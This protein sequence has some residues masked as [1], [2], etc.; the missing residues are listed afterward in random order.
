LAIKLKGEPAAMKNY[1]RVVIIG[2]CVIYL[3][4]QFEIVDG[5]KMDTKTENELEVIETMNTPIYV[6]PEIDLTSQK[7]VSIIIQ[8]KTK[9][10]KIA[11]IEALAKGLTLSFEEATKDVEDSHIRFHKDIQTLL[12]QEKV[13]YSI[14]RSYKTVYGVAMELPASEIKRLLNSAEISTI[15]A[16][17]EI[18]LDP[19]ILPY[20]QM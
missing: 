2:L 15:H 7:K 20:E 9:P 18:Q 11:V 3:G 8:F 13:P 17:K 16:D 14:T 1:F 6:D 5:R 12:E 10:A 19:P 4:C